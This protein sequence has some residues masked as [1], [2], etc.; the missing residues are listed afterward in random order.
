MKALVL[1]LI[2]VCPLSISPASS[3]AARTWYVKSDG[4]GDVP[5]IQAGIDSAGVGDT[6]LVAPGR[7]TWSNQGTGDDYGMILFYRAVTGFMLRSEAG[8]EHTTLD[9]EQQGRVI[10]IMAYNDIVIDGFTVTG[11]KAPV[12]YNSGGGLIGHLSAPLIR[13]CI[14]IAN[15]AQHGGGVWYGGVSA[16]TFEHCT[17]TDNEAELG[18]GV[19]LVNS[20]TNA[21]FVDCIINFNT[22]SNRGGGVLVYHYGVDMERC[23]I[24]KNT[25]A[26]RG[27]G[28]HFERAEPSSIANCT[29]S[30]NAAPEG[31]GINLFWESDLTVRKSVIAFCSDGAALNMNPDCMLDIGCCVI[32]GNADGDTIPRDAIDAGYNIFIDPQFC[33]VKGSANY[34]LQIDSP[35]LPFNN[36]TGLYCGLIGAHPAACG[37]VAAEK[38]SWSIIKKKLTD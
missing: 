24:Y 36:P 32:F 14:F 22:A 2:I 5:T 37:D 1:I 11:G 12:T 29:V 31:G 9:A 23:T 34:T 20:S 8:P 3:S 10:Y 18:A 33:G 7:Y 25:A 4:T 35:C 26:I 38:K 28:L 13:N 19:C 15:R 30:E 16:P 27:G 17:F 6:V 21:A